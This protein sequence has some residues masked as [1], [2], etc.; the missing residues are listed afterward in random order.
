M[1]ERALYMTNAEL[2]SRVVIDPAI[3]AGKP[4]IRGLRISVDHVL[5]SLAAGLTKEELL[6]D[7]P[8]LESEDIR[9]CL[10]CAAQLVEDE[11]VYPILK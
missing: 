9:A 10:L 7:Y 6:E 5:R 8:D 1:R 4:I 11:R 2:L 3:L